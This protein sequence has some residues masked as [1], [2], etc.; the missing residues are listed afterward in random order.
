MIDTELKNITTGEMPPHFY[1]NNEGY[2][3]MSYGEAREVNITAGNQP[4]RNTGVTI[5]IDGVRTLK[6][7]TDNSGKLRYDLLTVQHLKNRG[8]VSNTNHQQYTFTATGYTPR[9]FTVSQLKTTTTIN[10]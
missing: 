7:T 1:G 5:T 3:E 10:L 8:N 9:T 6:G 4:L 2:M